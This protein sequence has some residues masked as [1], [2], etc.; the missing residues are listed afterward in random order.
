MIPVFN[1]PPGRVRRGLPRRHARDGAPRQHRDCV[2]AGSRRVEPGRDW[3]VFHTGAPVTDD[4][5]DAAFAVDTWDGLAPID[6]FSPGTPDHPDCSATLIVE[7]STPESGLRLTGLGIAADAS[8]ALPDVEVLRAKAALYPLG[9]DVFFTCG[10]R[11]AALPRST[12]IH[13]PEVA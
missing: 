1:D 5:S 8:L 13:L 2:G 6:R 3:L 12:S 11:L 10:D 7:V 9:R 4:V